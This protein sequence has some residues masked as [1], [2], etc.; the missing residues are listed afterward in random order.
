MRLE[1]CRCCFSTLSPKETYYVGIKNIKPAL[2]YECQ[3]YGNPKGCCERRVLKEIEELEHK[4]HDLT[5]NMGMLQ[6]SMRATPKDSDSYISLNNQLVERLKE[7]KVIEA[8]LKRKYE[9]KAEILKDKAIR[10]PNNYDEMGQ[11]KS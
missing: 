5:V 3:R 8:H 10:F 9:I 4:A 1:W 2:C 7:G 6:I 11:P